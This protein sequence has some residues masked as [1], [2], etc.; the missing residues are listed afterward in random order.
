[1]WGSKGG[2]PRGEWAWLERKHSLIELTVQFFLLFYK[3]SIDYTFF[4]VK[5]AQAWT[6]FQQVYKYFAE[7]GNEKKIETE[8]NNSSPVDNEWIKENKNAKSS[9]V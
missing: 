8:E 7:T 3:R 9:Q 6:L 4:S 5:K 2:L 1:M